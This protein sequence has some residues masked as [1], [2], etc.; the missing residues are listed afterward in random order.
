MVK[1]GSGSNIFTFFLLVE[2]RSLS[3]EPLAEFVQAFIAMKKE[4][5]TDNRVERNSPEAGAGL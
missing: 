5:T 1:I 2:M 3:K 4:L